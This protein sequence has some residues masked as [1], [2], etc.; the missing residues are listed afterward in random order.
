[1]LIICPLRKQI[2]KK[3]FNIL[4]KSAFTE[5]V[6]IKVTANE[7]L[8]RLGRITKNKKK[9]HFSTMKL[10]KTKASSCGNS[11]CP[12]DSW[13]CLTPSLVSRITE[14]DW[15]DCWSLDWDSWQASGLTTELA[16]LDRQSYEHRTSVFSLW[17]VKSSQVFVKIGFF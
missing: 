5:L 7:H 17:T 6:R 10:R 13:V 2:Y 15:C 3:H 9:K 4:P 11:N 14:W 16:G 12:R 1:M 8:K